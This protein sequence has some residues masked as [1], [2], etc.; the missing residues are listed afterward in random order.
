MTMRSFVFGLVLAGTTVLLSSGMALAQEQKQPPE[1]RGMFKQSRSFTQGREKIQA[2]RQLMAREDFE[3]AAA[4][5][6]TMLAE[7][8]D[9]E[10]LYNLLCTCYERLQADQ[11][12]VRL[13]TQRVETHPDVFRHRL[14]L[15]QAHLMAEDST[16]VSN[17][18][19]EALRLAKND[20]ERLDVIEG[21]ITADLIDE[22]IVLIDSLAPLVEFRVPLLLHRGAL[23]EKK[24]DYGG[25]VRQYLAIVGDTSKLASNA[26]RK[27]LDLLRFEGSSPVVEEALME[28][29]DSISS[30]R[31]LRVLSSHYRT[32]GDFSHAFELALRQD[33]LEGSSGRALAQ[34]MR[35]CRDQRQYEEATRTGQH[36]LANLPDSPERMRVM[37]LLADVHVQTGRFPEAIACYDT[38]ML[39][40]ALERDKSEALYQ[41]GTIYL[42]H[43]DD[44]GQ[45]EVYY[46]SVCTHY[47]RG[48]GYGM[49]LM[50][51]PHCPLR[52]GELDRAAQ[53]FARLQEKKLT[54]DAAEEISYFLALIDFCQGRF[55]SAE[56][57]FKRLMV[58]YPRGYYVNDALELQLIMDKAAGD[59]SLLMRYSGA[60]LYEGRGM[61]DSAMASLQLVTE[62]TNQV[63][64]DLALWRMTELSLRRADTTA[65]LTAVDRL[66]EEQPESYYLPYGLKIKADILYLEEQTQSEARE[67]YLLLLE[68]YADYPFGSEVRER[69]RLLMSDAEIG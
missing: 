18:Y 53:E 12:L 32:K 65:A 20:R 11:K 8:P 44:P 33:Q 9:H 21:M 59:D 24:K 14:E 26:E 41:I 23:L 63:L 19:Q 57:A 28:Q 15:A 13:V 6:E 36:I 69:L 10:L 60:F 25:A 52:L 66:A 3:G 16:E 68:K 56:V 61:S 35:S 47:A 49:A 50:R 17:S 62:A 30:V 43:L 51:R 64:A 58:D 29:I 45:A 4:L 34:Y 55:D 42:E 40:T 2:V 27:I 31:A 37:L 5:L 46:D 39:T 67:I 22:T 54:D 48:A 7:Q 38:V 1:Q